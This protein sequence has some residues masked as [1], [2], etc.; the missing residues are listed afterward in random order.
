VDDPLIYVRAI[1][2]AAALSV[3]GATFFVVLIADPAL[4]LAN[5]DATLGG[6]ARVSYAW[7]AWI[8]LILTVLSGAAWLIFVASGVTDRSPAEVLTDGTVWTLLLETGFG[9]DWL[10]RFLIGCSLAAVLVPLLRTQGAKSNAL[11]LAAAVLSAA[12]VGSLAW[13]GH[14][15]GGEGVEGIVHPAG[16]VLHLIAAAAWVGTLLPLA[17]LLATAGQNA[18]SLTAARIATVRFSNLGI[19]SVA[20]LLV[21]GSINTW[22]LAGSIPALTETDY[23]RPL[24]V[25][26]ALFLGMVAIAAVNRLRLTPRLVQGTGNS[27]HSALR[28]LRRNVAVE[29]AAGAIVIAIVAVL[30]VTPPGHLEALMPQGHHH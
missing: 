14:A 1:H 11:K 2:F 30:G 19:A 29:I 17:V 4:R 8:G 13:A 16:D 21:T 3:A 23:G 6:R 24:L 12:L 27:S 7:I 18:A 26:I 9:H 25:K 22:Y 5:S 10:L 28:K 20:T 15:A